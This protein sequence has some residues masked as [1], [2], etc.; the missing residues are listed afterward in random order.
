MYFPL[1]PMMAVMRKPA[2]PTM[3]VVPPPQRAPSLG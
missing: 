2:K 1:P 3:L